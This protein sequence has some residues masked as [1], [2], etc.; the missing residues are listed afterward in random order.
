[1]FKKLFGR[2]D[3]SGAEND[4]RPAPQASEGT[5]RPSPPAEKKG[6]WSLFKKGLSKTRDGLK[7]LFSLRRA[8]DDAFVGELET[9]L[10]KADFGPGAVEELIHGEHGVRRA[11]KEH[12]IESAADV[13]EYLKGVLKEILKKRDNRLSRAE[14]GPTVILVAGV[15]GTGKTTSIAKLAYRLK[16]EGH[17][18][19]LAAADTFRAAAVEQLTIWS[20]RAGIEIVTGESN[21]D[22]ASV[23][24]RAAETSVEKGASYLIVDTAGRLHTQKNL[25]RELLKIRSVLGKKIP[26]AP[27]EA[28]LVLDATVGQN[29]LSQA[30]TFQEAI[31]ITGIILAKLDG[32]AKGGIV[33]AIN[34][35]LD[36]P[37]K[38]V[39]VGEQL[40]DLQPFNPDVFADALLEE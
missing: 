15:N 10:Y 24:F 3:D 13:R 16:S 8:L 26:G 9:A 27:H 22:P 34:N 25:M 18:V 33:V 32:T 39:G 37:V 29:A 40:E 30:R 23:A 21:A 38:F 19:V 7:S 12:K 28:L 4:P 6:L 11:W 35:L 36:I 5:Q 20:Q 14:S 2:K 1:M 31:E 17:D